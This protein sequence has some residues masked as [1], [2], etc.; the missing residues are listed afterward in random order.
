MTIRLVATDLDGTLVRTDKTISERTRQAIE[1]AK[2]LGVTVIVVTGRSPRSLPVTAR[3]VGLTGLAICSNGAVLY[4][5]D[6]DTVV[7]QALIAAETASRV[8]LRLREAAPGVAFAYE[9]ATS[10]GREPAFPPRRVRP[11]YPE[12][13][14]AD[15][16]VFCQESVIE[17]FAQHPQIKTET[18]L[19]RT[20]TAAGEMVSSSYAGY[21]VVEI[22]PAGIDKGWG[23]Q[24]FCERLGIHAAEVIAFGDM[25][26]DLSMLAWAGHAVAMANAHPDVLKQAHEITA[27]NMEDGVAVVLE[28]LLATAAFGRST[29][30][31]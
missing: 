11:E 9:R 4:D 1:R 28:R 10:Y 3:E 30:A 16:L 5:L 24:N 12:E 23:V 7:Q 31:Y 15:A 21:P 27:S 13:E 6:Q 2:A 8:V 17:L 26:N 22:T 18:L 19:E 25:P 20:Q 29:H 14:I